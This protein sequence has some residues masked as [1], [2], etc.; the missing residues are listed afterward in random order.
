MNSDKFFYVVTALVSLL[1][2]GVI[3]FFAQS[4]NDTSQKSLIVDQN[5]LIGNNAN[6]KG[7]LETAKVVL[8]EFSDFQCPACKIYHQ[9]IKRILSE[10]SES[11]AFVYKHFPLISIHNYSRQAAIA[12]E[13]AKKQ[14]KFF[15]YADILFE[16]QSTN[17]NPL[18]EENFVEIAKQLELNV[19]KFKADLTHPE[20]IE[21]VQTDMNL[22][23]SLGLNS[24]PTFYINGVKFQGDDLYGEV[25]KILAEK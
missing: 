23:D 25:K 11:I 17:E 19:E 22:A 14:D 13:A 24:T 4:K 6:I 18:K 8:V 20:V 16:R 10:N 15:E 3:L 7:N 9:E 1:I 21:K 5:V 12:S 2:F